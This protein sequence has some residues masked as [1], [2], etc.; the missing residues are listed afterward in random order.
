MVYAHGGGG[1]M[2]EPLDFK[3]WAHE[4][5]LRLGICLIMPK[6]RLA[7]EHKAPVGSEDFMKAFLYFH[8]N[9]AQFGFH[10]EMMAM[11]AESGGGIICLGA[12]RLMINSGEISKVR[13]CFLH[14]TMIGGFHLDVAEDQQT[15]SE[16]LM[17]GETEWAWSCHSED[18]EKAKSE[19]D[20]NIFPARM[21][22]E[23]INKMPL[24]FIMTSEACFLRRDSIEF[25]KILIKAGKLGGIQDLAGYQH[26]WSFNGGLPATSRF[27]KEW[28]AMFEASTGR[29]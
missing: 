12:I 18:W 6:Y 16:K 17:M 3:I 23:D 4:L 13:S 27:F 11:A 25:A 19:K 28:K 9:A 21:C 26:G 15:A 22:E 1:I 24:T 29:K 20:V 7:P 10:A 5:V 2:S 14:E 8:Q